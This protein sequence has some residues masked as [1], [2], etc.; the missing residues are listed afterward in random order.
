MFSRLAI[1]AAVLLGA[2][3][4]ASPNALPCTREATV[5]SPNIMGYVITATAATAK[6][7]RGTGSPLECGSTV[8][9]C[10]VLSMDVSPPTG[11][12]WLAYMTGGAKAV[13]IGTA[14]DC[15]KAR[16]DAATAWTMPEASGTVTL[17]VTFSKGAKSGK[18][19]ATPICSYT[20]DDSDKSLCAATPAPASSASSIAGSMAVAVVSSA[21]AL[22]AS[23]TA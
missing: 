3:V 15:S 7:K 10:E 4:D 14:Q 22:F 23:S 13:D 9:S 5:G 17:G 1:V 8:K 16:S 6:L 18:V 2:T 12:K 11:A 21:L 19:E 20:V